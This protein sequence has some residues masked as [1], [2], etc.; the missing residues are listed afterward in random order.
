MFKKISLTVAA[1]TLFLWSQVS[2]A[3]FEDVA[4]N[5]PHFEAINYLQ[6]NGIVEGYPDNTFRPDQ[7][8]NRAEALK[9]ILLG[10][11]VFV[12]DIQEQEIFPDV[13][14]D[15]WYGKYVAKAKNLGV[16]KGDD[17]TGMFR[18]GD[19]INLAEILKILVETKQVETSF[20]DNAP[21]PDVPADSWFAPY[22]NYASSVSLLDESG[23]ENVYPATLVD[24]GLM[25]ELMYRLAQRP[26][27]YQEGKASYYGMAFHGKT[28]ASGEVFDASGFTAAH[29]TFPFNTWLKVTNTENN[30]S[31]TVRVNDR[32][33][34]SGDR[35]IDLSKAAFEAIAS[36]SRGV[37]DVTIEPTSAPPESAF[38]TTDFGA[39]L[40]DAAECAEKNNLRYLS[41]TSYENITLNN[42]IPNRLVEGEILTLSGST[43]S[44]ADMVSAFVVDKN[45]KQY[46]FYGPTKNKNFN[47]N[48]YFPDTGIFKLGILPGES[49]NSIIQEIKVIPETCADESQDESLAAPSDLSI[50]LQDGDTL[51]SWN[52]GDYELFKITFTQGDN[53]NTYFLYNTGELMPY[54]RDFKDFDEGTVQ[55]KV[56]GADLA[57]KSLLESANIIWSNIATRSFTALEHYEYIINNDEVEI[58]DI[59]VSISQNQTFEISVKPKTSINAEAAIILPSGEVEEVMLQSSSQSPIT[60]SNGIKI[61]PPSDSGLTLSYKPTNAGLYFAEI[62]NADGLAA[63]NIPLYPQNQYPLTP[64][65]IELFGLSSIDLG[66]DLG[67]LRKQMLSLV[68]DDRADHGKSALA[69][70]SSLNNLAQYRADDMVANNYFS[71]WDLSGRSANDIKK[72]Y[73]ISQVVAENIAKDITVELAEYGLMRSALHRSNIL[74]DEWTRLGVGIAQDDDGG[75]VFVQILSANP[76]NIEDTAPL[77]QT[78]LGVINGNRSVNINLQSN[79]NDIAQNWSEKMVN[80]DFFDFTAPDSSTIVGNIRNAGITASLG[81]YIVGNT[82]FQSAVDQIA[83]NTQIAESHWINLGVGIKQDSLGIIKITLIYTE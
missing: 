4:S 57:T 22:F 53:S 28:T 33:P 21:Y 11:D 13:I 45:N 25:A 8:V 6:E 30:E 73:A 49:G 26:N 81:T 43:T 83:E 60:N 66:N 74:N 62:N 34:Y 68:N 48:V 44:S 75:Y 51:F 37:I 17:N 52:K 69:L 42:E 71:H 31:V 27:G 35:I 10:S 36:L 39:N 15:T 14:H 61:F 54:Y 29:R 72:N 41:K 55:V 38:D 56:Q 59:P 20:P 7:P 79:L 47:F 32:G 58:M 76:I 12:P 80:D 40:L 65:P 9:I 5:H 3:V 16:V 77:R 23:S 64:N 46:G 63:V 2:Y 67:A 70:D 1:L 82:S 19:T 18:P 50:G 24:R 78:V